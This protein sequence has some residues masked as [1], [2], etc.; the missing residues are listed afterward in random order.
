MA[1][2]DGMAERCFAESELA[3]WRSLPEFLKQSVFFDY[4]SC[5]EAFVKATGHGIPLGLEACVVDL[6][7]GHARLVS[8]PANCGKPEQWR[9][10]Q[11][12]MGPDH[13]SAVCYRGAERKLRLFDAVSWARG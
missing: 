3:Y 9:L 2:R 12:D 1:H 8:I 5:K 13:A 10:V 4:W 7:S 11:M 6:G